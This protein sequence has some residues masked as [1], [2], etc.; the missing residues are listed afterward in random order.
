MFQLQH[1]IAQNSRRIIAIAAITLSLLAAL[2]LASASQSRT[3]LWVA[4]H[5]LAPGSIIGQADITRVSADLGPAAKGYYAG[6]ATL[7]G[8]TVT[9]SVGAAE[10]IPLNA[11]A[12]PGSAT[13]YRHLPLGIARSDLPGD[14]ASGQ[15]VDLYSIPKDPGQAPAIVASGIHVQSVDNKSRDLGGAVTVLFLLHEKEIMAVMDALT[16]GRIVVVR[17]AL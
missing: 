9:R 17:N 10:F 12:Q 5:Q 2:G 6:S 13:D 3:P 15:R 4:A 14:L 1:F 8:N 7:I 11:L 16:T